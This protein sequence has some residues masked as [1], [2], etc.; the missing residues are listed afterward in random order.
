MTQLQL[1]M[2]INVMDPVT[3]VRYEQGRVTMPVF[4]LQMIAIALKVPIMTL[5]PEA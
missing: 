4:R 1:A 2:A 5:I 3:I